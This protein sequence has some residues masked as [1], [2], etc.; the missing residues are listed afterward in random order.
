MWF[1]KLLTGPLERI[2]PVIDT[3]MKHAGVWTPDHCDRGGRSPRFS[4]FTAG[5][6][7]CRQNTG[8][9]MGSTSCGCE[10]SACSSLRMPDCE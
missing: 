7:G 1:L 10:P 5:G 3:A 6:T 8:D 4:R 2:L 9:R